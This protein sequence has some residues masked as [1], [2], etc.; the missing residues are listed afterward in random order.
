MDRIPTKET[1]GTPWSAGVFLYGAGMP[2]IGRFRL[3]E[4][5]LI[6][7]NLALIWHRRPALRIGL[8]TSLL[9]ILALAVMYQFNDLWDAKDDLNN[10]KKDRRLTLLLLE[11]A[12]R[13][14]RAVAVQKIAIISV[15]ALFA[16]APAAWAVVGVFIV[17]TL[18][19]VRFKSVPVVDVFWVGV[20][21][22]AYA[23]IASPSRRMCMLVG[24]LTAIS[25]IFQMRSDRSVD[26]LNDVKTSAVCS[27]ALTRGLL[28][29]ACGTLFVA[30]LRESAGAWS[31]T[32]FLPMGLEFALKGKQ[33][34]W[35][36]SKAYF[37]LL[38]LSAL[39]RGYA[40]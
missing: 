31:F 39:Q 5:A 32:A 23:A 19:S 20:W 27:N 1:P 16:P 10:P 25:H 15:A 18:Y 26:S 37:A 28:F 33:A 4:G 6:A 30:L 38:L 17:N 35:L 11:H 7:V 22:F 24:L 13:F 3:G 40:N 14:Y 36:I 12:P 34:P 9:S 29:A 21:G 8:L 2:L